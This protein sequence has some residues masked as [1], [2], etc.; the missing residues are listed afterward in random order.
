MAEYAGEAAAGMGIVVAGTGLC[1]RRLTL[2]ADS[3]RPTAVHDGE[4]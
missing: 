4:A 1:L 3:M 2:R